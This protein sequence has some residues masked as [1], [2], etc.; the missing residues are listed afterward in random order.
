L[1]RWAVKK[2]RRC[3][4]VAADGGATEDSTGGAA[5]LS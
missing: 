3:K 2:A 5:V 4:L 1:F